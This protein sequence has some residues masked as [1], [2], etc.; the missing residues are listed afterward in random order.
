MH[1]DGFFTEEP[2]AEAGQ[3]IVTDTKT[4]E[5]IQGYGRSEVDYLSEEF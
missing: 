1:S 4:M 5:S 2:S 3:S